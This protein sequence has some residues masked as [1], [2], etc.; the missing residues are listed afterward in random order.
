MPFFLIIYQTNG[1]N[2][3]HSSYAHFGI[4]R[5]IHKPHRQNFGHFLPPPLHGH[6]YWVR[7]ICNSLV[8]W[9]TPPPQLYTLFMDTPL[10]RIHTP[11]FL[12]NQCLICCHDLNW[13]QRL[14]YWDSYT[15]NGNTFAKG[16]PLWTQANY[17][18]ND[19]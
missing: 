18:F 14:I 9:L 7:L 1:H 8:I 12:C 16:F 13:I 10:Q 5:V 2:L 4:L 19:L 3:A 11:Y 15:K 6:F 17:F